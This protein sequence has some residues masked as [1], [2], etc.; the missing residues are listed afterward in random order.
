MSFAVVTREPLVSADAVPVSVSVPPAATAT[1]TAAATAV[2]REVRGVGT[3]MAVGLPFSGTDGVSSQGRSG[4]GPRVAAC[5]SPSGLPS[6]PM[7]NC[8]GR[9]LSSNLTLRVSP[10][11][12]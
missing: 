7:G 6:A 4:F 1:A 10:A 2:R 5:R 9:A 3:D 11:D 8:S 12:V